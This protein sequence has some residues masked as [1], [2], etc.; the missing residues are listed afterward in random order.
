MNRTNVSRI[1]T[2][3]LLGTSLFTIT[4]PALSQDHGHAGPRAG[5]ITEADRAKLRE[6]MQ[7]GMKQ[8]LDR[9]AARLEIK[10]SQQDAWAAYRT[11]R[12]SMFATPPQLPPTDA[13]AAV[14]AR[15]R[16]DMAKRHADYLAVMADATAKLQE[17][18]DPNQRKVLNEMSRRGGGHGK[19]HGGPRGPRGFH[20]HHGHAGNPE[21]QPG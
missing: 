1:V 7:S 3:A 19:G 14:I 17:A 13:D 12:E 15:F 2:A 20:S 4:V 11:A 21:R 10:S 16:A 8:R 18:L 9:M 6:R 5:Q